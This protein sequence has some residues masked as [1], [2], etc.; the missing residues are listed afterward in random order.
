MVK[1]ACHIGKIT[2]PGIKISYVRRVGKI[3]A[4]ALLPR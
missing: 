3:A 2:R 1:I 4:L